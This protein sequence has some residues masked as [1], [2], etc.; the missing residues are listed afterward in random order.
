VLFFPDRECW[1]TFTEADCPEGDY[2]GGHALV[3][4]GR[5]LSPFSVTYGW[6]GNHYNYE[7]A[8]ISTASLIAIS[9]FPT[10]VAHAR[11]EQEAVNRANETSGGESDIVADIA[12]GMFGIGQVVIIA[13]G[14]I[15]NVFL[16]DHEEAIAWLTKK[17]KEL[18]Q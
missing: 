17:T 10:E 18:I 6:N 14:E 5:H 7:I 4:K 12:Q 15:P 3:S 8:L 16:D 13:S 11:D 1:T 2:L 9:E